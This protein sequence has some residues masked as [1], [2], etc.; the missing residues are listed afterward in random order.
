MGWL[1][2]L[3]RAWM[4]A[5]RN[6]RLLNMACLIAA[7]STSTAVILSSLDAVERLHRHVLAG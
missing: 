6:I 3:A 7:L 2:V 4:S 5:P 1:G